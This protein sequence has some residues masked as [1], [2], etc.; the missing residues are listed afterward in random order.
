MDTDFINVT[1]C[2]GDLPSVSELHDD[3]DGSPLR[4]NNGYNCQNLFKL[5]SP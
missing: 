2:K 5:E 3:P 1:H 4:L